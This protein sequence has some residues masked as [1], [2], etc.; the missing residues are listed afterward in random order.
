MPGAAIVLLSSIGM[1]TYYSFLIQHSSKDKGGFV[2]HYG[3][4]HKMVQKWL[5]EMGI[6]GFDEESKKAAVTMNRTPMQSTPV[7]VS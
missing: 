4:V 6:T 1:F 3:L 5:K 2:R 7:H